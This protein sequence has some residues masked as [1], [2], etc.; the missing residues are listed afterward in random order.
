MTA[1]L[2]ASV[3]NFVQMILY[4][5]VVLYAPALA[6]E[7]TTGL[8]SMISVL[9][10]GIICTFYSSIGGMKAV[11]ATD[12]FQG[13]LMFASLFSIIG[14]ACYDFDGGIAEAWAIATKGGRLDF[15]KYSSSIHYIKYC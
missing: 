9:V 15:W 5:G 11:L 4:T 7:A 10:I 1:R 14:V 8:S 2:V 13:I 12:V 3:A 6:L